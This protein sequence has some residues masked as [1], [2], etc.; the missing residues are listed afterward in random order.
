MSGTFVCGILA[1]LGTPIYLDSS[2]CR[3]LLTIKT[4]CVRATFSPKSK[5]DSTFISTAPARSSG[6]TRKCYCAH[7]SGP[8]H[9]CKQKEPRNNTE[10]RVDEVIRVNPWPNLPSP[11]R[12]SPSP[13][14]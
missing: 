10:I 9:H 6:A 1:P 11:A 8:P 13:V 2:R 5:F 3:Q 7:S 14:L 12:Y 4:T